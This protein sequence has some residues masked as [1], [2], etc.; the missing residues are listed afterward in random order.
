L[1]EL[2]IPGRGGIQ[3]KHLVSDVNGT[4]AQ[5]GHL[6]PGV[7]SALLALG[8]RLQLHL[9]TADTHGQQNL[10][11]EQLDLQAVRIQKGDESQAKAEYVR[12]IGPDEV[13]A[14][15]QGKNDAGML[16][17]ATIGIAVLSQEGLAIEALQNADVLA[18]DILSALDLLEHPVRLVAT[19]RQ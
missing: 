10:I 6:I 19:L 11:D 9:L 4:L 13:V 18:S 7:A 15:G 1:I 16:R 5:D 2:T 3:L 17:E 8:D 12:K 14:L